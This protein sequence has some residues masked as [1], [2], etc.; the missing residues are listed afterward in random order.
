MEKNSES[1]DIHLRFDYSKGISMRKIE[2]RN[3]KE[4]YL[5]LERYSKISFAFDPA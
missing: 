3:T 4:N 5:L 1:A 2:H